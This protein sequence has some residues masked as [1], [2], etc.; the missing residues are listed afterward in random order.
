MTTPV[1]VSEVNLTVAT[2]NNV[3][4]NI[5]TTGLG[6]NGALV[7]FLVGGIVG[8]NMTG[9]SFS[10]PTLGG[11]SAGWTE[12]IAL[13][14][15]AASV[16]GAMGVWV[17]LNPSSSSSINLALAHTGAGGPTNRISAVVGMYSDV[18]SITAF[19]VDDDG[20]STTTNT[21]TNAAGAGNLTVGSW[22]HGSSISSVTSGTLRGTI[23]N[24]HTDYANGCLAFIEGDT[25]AFSSGS[26]DSN[27]GMQ[28]KLVGAGGAAVGEA[29]PGPTGPGDVRGGPFGPVRF[30]WQQQ[31]GADRDRTITAA[32]V[33]EPGISGSNVSTPHDAADVPAGDFTQVVCV[34]L[35][36][37][38]PAATTSLHAKYDVAATGTFS[39]KVLNGKTL[40]VTYSVA[41]ANSNATSTVVLPIENEDIVWLKTERTSGDGLVDLFYSHDPPTTTPETVTWTSLQVNRSTTAGVLTAGGTA[42][43]DVGGDNNGTTNVAK[44]KFFRAATYDGLGTGGTKTSDMRPADWTSGTSWVSSTTGETW[45]LNGAATVVPATGAAATNAVAELATGTGTAFNASV[46]ILVDTGH[47]AGTGAANN[48]KSTVAPNAGNAAGTGTSFGSSLTVAPTAGVAAG[49]GAA[50]NSGK[51]V[52]PVA[53]LASGT[54]SAFN[55]TETVAPTAGVAAGTGTAYDSGKTVAPVAGLAAGTGTAYDATATTGS[56]TNAPAELATGTGTAYNASATVA[57]AAGHAAATGTA[58]NGKATVAPTAGLASGTGTAFDATANTSAVTNAAAELATGTGT[59]FNAKATVAPT[60]G[61]AAGTGA[62]SNASVTVAPRA[63]VAAGTGT[64]NNATATIAPT[65]GHAAGTGTALVP[66]ATIAPVAGSATGTGTAYNATGG[67]PVPNQIGPVVYARDPQPIH[68]QDPGVIRARNPAV[69]H[70]QDPT[71]VRGRNPKPQGG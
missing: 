31:Q 33:L 55:A 21:M 3:N 49:T 41:A 43:T 29:T 62:A 53:G 60:A 69:T 47:A 1:F 68:A 14:V 40:T 17:C 71:V 12:K 35:D 54:G 61:N 34:A 57:P 37:W 51:T 4:A 27:M 11:S 30:Q 38:N 28:V 42:R 10:T 70:A 19:T 58:N 22:S 39:V 2:G 56:A 64:A 59:A 18:D 63:G 32:Y 23:N 20:G 36:F 52:A 48:A 16:S 8:G 24:A 9:L 5:D 15:N 65:A 13:D 67:S 7:V 50:L 45:T 46:A 44:G 6:A 26:S 66:T 25:Q